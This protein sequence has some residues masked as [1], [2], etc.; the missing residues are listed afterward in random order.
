MPG[1]TFS[2]NETTGHRTA[3]KGY[4]EA[5]IISD[6]APGRGV[7]GGVSQ[8]ATTTYNAAYF[9][10]LK[11][12]GHKEHSFY[13]SRYPPGREA[14]VFQ[15]ADGSTAIDMKF[16]NIMDTG[17]A[18][19]TVWTPQTITVRL[20]GTKKYEVESITGPKT[21]ITEPQPRQGPAAN[22]KPSNG[23]QGFTITDT[24]VVR[25]VGTG[26]EVSRTTRTVKYNPN[27]KIVCGGPPPN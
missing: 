17:I 6:G 27:P 2:L 5:G 8:F 11:D 24:R 14:T 13:I 21:N 1:E 18:I 22:C 26:R 25:E 20:W 10:G 12:A 9:A 4:V 15:N 3:A 16:T 19:Q 7:G 23:S